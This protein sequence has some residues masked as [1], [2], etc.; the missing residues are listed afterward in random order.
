MSFAIHVPCSCVENE[1]I[2]MPPFSDKLYILYG[3]YDIKPEFILDI[4]L[5][6]EYDQWRFCEHNQIAIEMDIGQTIIGIKPYIVSKYGSRFINLIN[7]L[8]DYNGYYS[9]EYNKIELS[10]ELLELRIIEP[11]YE[12]R[13]S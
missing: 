2:I 9:T 8:P 13:W 6:K 10:K 4:K 1:A 7:F 12:Y 3:I 11:E 5:E